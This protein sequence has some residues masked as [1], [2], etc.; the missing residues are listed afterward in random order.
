MLGRN[1]TRFDPMVPAHRARTITLHTIQRA[2]QARRELLLIVPLTALTIVA[3][4]FREKI[5]GV[6]TPVRLV[7]AVVLVVLGWAL[8]RDLRRRGQAAPFPPGGPGAGRTGSV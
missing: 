7:A 3:F 1:R 2:R 5:F 4:I 6:D 8:A